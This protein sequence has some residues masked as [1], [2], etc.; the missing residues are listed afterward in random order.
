MKLNLGCGNTRIEGWI[1]VD[2]LSGPAVDVI[3]D[4]TKPLPWESN[5]VDEVLAS[6]VLEHIV[7]FEDTIREI[8]RILRPG[9]ILT[10]KVPYGLDPYTGHVRSFYPCT[11]DGFIYDRM[12]THRGLESA[13]LFYELERKYHRTIPYRWHIENYLG[14]KFKQYGRFGKRSQITWILEKRPIDE[15]QGNEIRPDKPGQGDSNER[16]FGV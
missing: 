15:I 10:I 16:F 2:F 5:S 9:G 1:G 3:A 8:H 6:H 11:L 14:I 12:T 13:P 7:M 4:L